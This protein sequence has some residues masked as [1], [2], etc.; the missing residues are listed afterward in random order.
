MIESNHSAQVA[1]DQTE[2]GENGVNLSGGQRQRVALARAA[3]RRAA[4]YL[5]DDP[6][7]AVDAETA[8]HIF[9]HLICGEMTWSARL[10]V[11]HALQVLP[12]A[13][14]RCCAALQSI[15]CCVTESLKVSL[16]QGDCPGCT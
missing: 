9:S 4:V 7:S 15:T 14:C 6:L 11:T 13:G 16:L 2:I 12:G 3:Y 8:G 10:L 5:L 1:G